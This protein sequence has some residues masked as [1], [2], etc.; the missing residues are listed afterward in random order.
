MTPQ[1][2]WRQFTPRHWQQ[3][4]LLPVRCAIRS[5]NRKFLQGKLDCCSIREA[6]RRYSSMRRT[7]CLARSNP[8]TQEANSLMRTLCARHPLPSL[9]QSGCPREAGSSVQKRGPGPG[10]RV[11][12]LLHCPR[13]STCPWL[14]LHS[15][16]WRALLPDSHGGEG[17]A[18]RPPRI[19][20]S[21]P[22][23]AVAAPSLLLS[24]LFLSS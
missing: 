24:L 6:H 23:A 19:D 15:A 10:D 2:H 17:A 3:L 21:G 11:S 12:R 13:I 14:A 4:Q 9:T 8:V 5:I 1:F 22:P 20:S 16:L 7:A 18:F